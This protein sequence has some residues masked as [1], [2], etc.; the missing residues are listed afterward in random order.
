MNAKNINQLPVKDNKHGLDVKQIYNK[1]D[2]QCMHVVLD[3]YQTMKPHI[4]PCD[5]F[6]FV[7]EGKATIHIGTEEQEFEAGTIIESP[8]DITHHISN[9]TS[10][11][12]K[13][14]VCKTGRKE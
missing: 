5:V 6:F 14:L 7:I 1:H 12:I 3:A 9:N 8:A 2:I 13:L 10:N 11:P 4:T